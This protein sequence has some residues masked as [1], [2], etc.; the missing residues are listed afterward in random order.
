MSDRV[1][2]TPTRCAEVQAA[3]FFIVTDGLIE[4]SGGTDAISRHAAKKYVQAACSMFLEEHRID[5]KHE[6][7]EDST[8]LLFVY[9]QSQTDEY[10]ID[11]DLGSPYGH[12]F[13]QALIDIGYHEDQSLEGC[14][15]VVADTRAKL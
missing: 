4:A 13:G 6:S 1:S 3:E 7:I 15:K 14:A 8:F 9:L 11:T 5:L 12:A 2:L 10:R